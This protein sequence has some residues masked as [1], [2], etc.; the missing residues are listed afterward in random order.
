MSLAASL[1]R[2]AQWFQNAVDTGALP[3]RYIER[4]ESLKKDAATLRA[5]QVAA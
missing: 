3:A 5:R 2:R 4:V 1:D